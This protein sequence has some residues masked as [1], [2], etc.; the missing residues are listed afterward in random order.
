MKNGCTTT[1]QA[2]KEDGIEESLRE[3]G[4]RQ[5]LTNKKMLFCV[6][7]YFRGIIFKEYMKSGQ[8]IN[9]TTYNN[10]LIKFSDA[11]GEKRSKEFRR[12]IVFLHQDNVRPHVST[13]TICTLYKLQWDLIQDPPYSPDMTPS[14]Y[15]L[16]PHL[17]HVNPLG[18]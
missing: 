3:S 13:M 1:I 4:A 17:H 7:Y 15:Y 12:K 14:D 6:W 5:K 9:S 10:M 16:F 11:I 2:V 18:G 8:I